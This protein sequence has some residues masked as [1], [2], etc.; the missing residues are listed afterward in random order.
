MNLTAIKIVKTPLGFFV[1]V[2]L[3]IEAI[4]GI[5]AANFPNERAVIVYAMIGLIFLL[6][7]IVC[8]LACFKPGALMGFDPELAKIRENFQKVESLADGIAGEWE[9]R[10]TFQRE[11]GQPPVEVVGACTFTKGRYG[12][13]AQGNILQQ[14]AR[15]SPAFAFKEVFLQDDG[16]TFIFEVPIDLGHATLGVGQVTFVESKGKPRINQLKGNWAVV[17]K[18]LQGK[19]QFDRKSNQR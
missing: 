13:R 1:L 16:L 10:T 18:T 3:L 14:D 6:V 11:A 12:I 15:P 2:V 7:A 4:F 19:A 8:L 9:F 17:G 5:S